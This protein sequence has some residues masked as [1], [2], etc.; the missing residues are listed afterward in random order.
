MEINK[1]T[2]IGGIGKD[3]KTEKV[4]RFD[5]KMGDIISI[6]GPTRCGKT[7]LINDIELFANLNTPSERIVLIN[8]KPIPRLFCLMKLRMPGY[9]GRKP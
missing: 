7:T 3:G 9:T 6:V 1:I 8:D 4:E 5:L 2:I